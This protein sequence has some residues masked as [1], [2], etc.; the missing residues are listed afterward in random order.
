[1]GWSLYDG[2]EYHKKLF[3][4]MQIVTNSN[5]AVSNGAYHGDESCPWPDVTSL[6]PA[7]LT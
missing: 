2:K 5:I 7:L 3:K 4:K 1:M 6:T